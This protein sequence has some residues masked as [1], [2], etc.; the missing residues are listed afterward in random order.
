MTELPRDVVQRLYDYIDATATWRNMRLVCTRWRDASYLNQKYWY[1]WLVANV[2]T[3]PTATSSQRH[4]DIWCLEGLYC[5][6]PWHYMHSQREPI[7]LKTV[8]IH[9]Q[10]LQKIARRKVK[11]LSRSLDAYQ[12]ALDEARASI[13]VLQRDFDRSKRDL[14]IADGIA[15]AHTGARKKTRIELNIS[16]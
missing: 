13:P 14:E 9:Q 15:E 16:K 11:N 4:T 5:T 10:V 7:I 3:K 2:K 1:A 12:K 8:P 6:K